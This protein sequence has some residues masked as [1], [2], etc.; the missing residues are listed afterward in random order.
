M[1]RVYER[2]VMT[3]VAFEVN[4]IITTSNHSSSDDGITLPEDTT[5]F[6]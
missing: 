5:P 2:A 4:D 6:E 3:V 1:S